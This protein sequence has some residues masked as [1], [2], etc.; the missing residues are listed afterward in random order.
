MT[1]SYIGPRRSRKTSFAVDRF[2]EDP[3]N[4]IL[5]LPTEQQVKIMKKEMYK[6]LS[7]YRCCAPIDFIEGSIVSI[8]WLSDN[9]HKINNK[10]LLFDELDWC[11]KELF[12]NEIH[13]ITGSMQRVNISNYLPEDWAKNIE[14]FKKQMPE[15]EFKEQFICRYE[16]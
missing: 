6:K 13:L 3:R 15:K 1:I 14:E 7:K 8:L 5:V 16:E 4:S 11:L 2:L 9:S 10:K 12:K